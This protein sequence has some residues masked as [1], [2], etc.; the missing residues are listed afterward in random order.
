MN[1]EYINSFSLAIAKTKGYDRNKSLLAQKEYDRRAKL[2]SNY[3]NYCRNMQNRE[4]KLQ[5]LDFFIS[6]GSIN[7]CHIS[8]DTLF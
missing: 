6:M 5:Y 4:E 8:Q 3:R 1:K 2:A 7:S